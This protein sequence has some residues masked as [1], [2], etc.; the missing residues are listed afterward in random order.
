MA[1]VMVVDDDEDV[2]WVLKR[3][4]E[5]SGYEVTTCLSGE[6]ALQ[7]LEEDRPDVV[8]LDIMMPGI[9]GFETLDRIRDNVKTA[10]IPVVIVSAKVS[11][12][13]IVRGLEMGAND[14][15]TKPYNP[16]ILKAK[17]ESILKLREAERDLTDYILEVADATRNPMQIFTAHLEDFDTSALTEEQ[18]SNFNEI[19]K[20]GTLVA[21]NIK[22]LTARSNE[23]VRW[24]DRKAIEQVTPPQK[25]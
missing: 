21:E 18:K 11:E 16:T 23:Y 12:E 6:E 17:I 13:S 8:L 25:K 15:F 7:V 22:M 3:I 2:I 9:D 1:K 4:L 10:S 14:Y 24:K 19:L 5:K 20:A